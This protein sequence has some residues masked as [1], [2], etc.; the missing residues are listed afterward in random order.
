LYGEFLSGKI[1]DRPETQEIDGTIIYS[2]QV[3]R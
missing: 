2:V 3:F 1:L